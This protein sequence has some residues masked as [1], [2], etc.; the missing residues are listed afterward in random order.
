LV[1]KYADHPPLNWTNKEVLRRHDI[2]F[3]RQTPC[4][5]VLGSTKLL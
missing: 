3:K 5:W 1:S 2:E 4:D